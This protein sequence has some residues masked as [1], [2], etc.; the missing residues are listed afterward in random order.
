VGVGAEPPGAAREI[1]SWQAAGYR[2]GLAFLA[3][4]SAEFAIARVA[5]RVRQGG[6][7]VPNAVVRRR[8]TAGWESFERVFKALVDEWRLYD[9]SGPR[10]V[11]VD[12]RGRE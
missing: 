7:G 9:N 10:P 12:R 3:L 1:P 2:V 5:M 4:P 6:H 11:L 8:F